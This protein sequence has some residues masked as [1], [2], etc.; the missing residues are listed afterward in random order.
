MNEKVVVAQ[1]RTVGAV[2]VVVV[3]MVV[4]GIVV[5]GALVPD[6]GICTTYS[7]GT[8]YCTGP[9]CEHCTPVQPK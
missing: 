4:A 5:Y 9:A 8:I 1:E 7:N 2:I 6:P 3:S